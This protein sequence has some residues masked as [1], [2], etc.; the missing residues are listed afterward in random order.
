[1]GISGIPV[2]MVSG[3]VSNGAHSWNMAYADG[4]W[5]IVDATAAEYGYPQYMSMSEH[6]KLYGYNHS[7]NDNIRIQIS[8]AL[9]EAAESA[10]K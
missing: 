10:R 5:I 4:E 2:F 8:K 7:L 9:V 1:M 3:D 6:E